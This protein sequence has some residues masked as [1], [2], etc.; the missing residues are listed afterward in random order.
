MSRDLIN[1]IAVSLG[2]TS[3]PYCRNT[4]FS[5]V[6]RCDLSSGGPCEL[7]GECQHCLAKF[8]IGSV[9]TIGELH[10]R[11]ERELASQLCSCGGAPRLELRCDL[12]TEDCVFIAACSRCDS[13]WLIVPMPY[14]TIAA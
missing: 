3:C 14:G 10:A 6:L 4:R 2:K 12:E 9:E 1:Q 11:A 8:D 5:V 7:V 13:E